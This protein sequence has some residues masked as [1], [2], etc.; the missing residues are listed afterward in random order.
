MLLKNGRRLMAF[1]FG[2]GQVVLFQPGFG[3]F[4]GVGCEL[5]FTAPIQSCRLDSANLLEFRPR[6]LV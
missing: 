5:S 1:G 2:G 4:Q 3:T 6:P